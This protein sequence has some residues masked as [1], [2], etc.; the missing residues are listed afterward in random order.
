[1]RQDQS[2]LDEEFGRAVEFLQR[3]SGPALCE[4][5][6]LCYDAGKP[7]LYDAFYTNSQVKVGRLT[8]ADVL[9]YVQSSRFPTVELTIPAGVPLVPMTTFRFSEPIL[10][11]I[12]ERYRPA[13]RG[14]QFTLLVPKEEGAN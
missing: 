8:E 5:L 12:L 4:D 11:A 6:L 13:V 2:N 14:S 10:R 3:R 7:P 9:D 1:M